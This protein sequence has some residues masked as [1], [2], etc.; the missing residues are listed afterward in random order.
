MA[1]LNIPE[2]ELPK[3]GGQTNVPGVMSGIAKLFEVGFMVI[4]CR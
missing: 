3:L 4:K 2:S 1:L